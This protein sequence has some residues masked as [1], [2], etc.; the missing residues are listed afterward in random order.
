[1]DCWS[2]LPLYIGLGFRLKFFFRAGCSRVKAPAAREGG[3]SGLAAVPMLDLCSSKADFDW[4]FVMANPF[5]ASIGAGGGPTSDGR[6]DM[7]GVILTNC[8]FLIVTL[9]RLAVELVF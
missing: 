4:R 8:G 2:E 6:L 7:F 5:Y 1:M 3:A 9:F